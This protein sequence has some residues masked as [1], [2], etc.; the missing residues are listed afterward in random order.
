MIINRRRGTKVGKSNGDITKEEKDTGQATWKSTI[1]ESS[2]A[3]T[4]TG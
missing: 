2:K 3:E 1:V 4:T